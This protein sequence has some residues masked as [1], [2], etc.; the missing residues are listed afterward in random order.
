MTEPG[1]ADALREAREADAEAIAAIYNESILTGD[2]TMDDQPK[3]AG[4]ILG[5]MR[6]FSDRECLLVLEDTAARPG[7]PAPADATIRGWGIIKKYSERAGYRFACETAVYLRRDQIGR[8][9]GT[10]MKKALIA[11]CR[12][13]GYRH[14]VAKIF[15]DNEA[16]IGYNLKLGYEMVGVQRNIGFKNGRYVDVAILQ[17]V[18]PAAD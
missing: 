9:L 7:D 17:L 14:L 12:Q 16:S 11:R 13:L 3:T 15:A 8:G 5:W 4:D 6:A 10:R 1:A 2:A 18:L